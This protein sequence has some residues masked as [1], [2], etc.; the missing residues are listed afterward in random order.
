MAPSKFKGY[1]ITIIGLVGFSTELW[2]GLLN[3]LIEG[4]PTEFNK[5]EAS[6]WALVVPVIAMTLMAATILFWIGTTMM[7]IK[8]PTPLEPE[9][10]EE[11][12]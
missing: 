7:R 8:S 3:P 12:R 1:I 6:Y 2:Y 4:V 10:E 9:D 11:P 5:T